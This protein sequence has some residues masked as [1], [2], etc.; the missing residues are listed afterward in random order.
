[1]VLARAVD[2]AAATT[3]FVVL[4][5]SAF[6]VAMMFSIAARI[7]TRAVTGAAYSLAERGDLGLGWDMWDDDDDYFLAPPRSER[8]RR[9]SDV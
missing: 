2:V 5:P 7:A 4:K 6:L 1:L 9:K 3:N 8:K